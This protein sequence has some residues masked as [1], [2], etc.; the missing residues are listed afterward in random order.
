VS[1]RVFKE[2]ELVF[3][4][5][6]YDALREDRASVHVGRGS[7]D[8]LADAKIWLEPDVEIARVGRTLNLRQL[9]RA[10]RLVEANHARLLEAWN[11]HKS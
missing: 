4:F 9:R 6:S 1:P 3:W 10:V 8:D 2:G 11:D 5:H 7:Q